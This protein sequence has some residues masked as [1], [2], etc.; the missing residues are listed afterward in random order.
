MT[1][2]RRGTRVSTHRLVH[3][4][5]TEGHEVAALS[6]VDLDVAPGEMVG[7]LGPSGAGKSTLLSLLG[8]R[9][10]GQRRQGAHRRPRALVGLRPR[11]GRDAR[12]R[13]VADAP[14]RRRATCCRTSPPSRT[15]ASPSTPPAAAGKDSRPP[16]RAR[17]G[18]ASAAEADRPLEPL[19]PGTC[20]SP[21]LAV[22]I[23]PG[24]GCCSPTSR[25]AS[26]TTPPATGCSA[27]MRRDEPRA[28]HHGRA[29][30][31]RPRRR[32]LAC[33]ARS[34]SATAGSAGRAV[35]GGV[36]RGHP[37]GFLPL[38]RTSSTSCPRHAGAVRRSTAARW[39]RLE[40]GGRGMSRLG[41]TT[42]RSGTAALVAVAPISTCRPGRLVAV[43]GPSG[44]GKTSLLWAL[45]GAPGARRGRVSSTG[46]CSPAGGGGRAGAWCVPQGNGLARRSPRPRTSWCRCSTGVEVRDAH[47]RAHEALA[48]VG[49][50]ESGGHLIEELSGGQQQ[51]VALARALAARPRAAGRR[52]DQRP[53]RRNRE[54]GGRAAGRGRAWRLVV[55]ATHDPE[56]A[57]QA[58]GELHLDAGTAAGVAG[59]A[60]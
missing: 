36:R 41:P 29:G 4:Y 43:T 32:R 31:P 33:R 27:A 6:G 8:G 7:L 12:G 24:P 25:P 47:R 34:R 14:G 15:C 53:R 3:I 40:R 50:E 49:L 42:S 18:S 60:P 48:L 11:A 13:G 1:A 19:T 52:A 51:R 5:R 56:A 54:D 37:D 39:Y 23:A 55:L 59:P 28:R 46:R 38:P 26:S 58:D 10:P 22:A 9:V 2:P 16:G 44:A 45:A 30:H 20:S 57:A 35:R 21:S 17:P